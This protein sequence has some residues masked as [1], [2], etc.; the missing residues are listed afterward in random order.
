M[1]RIV[2]VILFCTACGGKLSEDQRKRLH[3]GMATQDIRRVT[4]ADLQ[5]SAL[6][7]GKLVISDIERVD[8]SLRKKSKIDSLAQFYHV[9]IY[10]LV[11]S[12]ELLREVEKQLVDAYVAGSG[13]GQVDDNL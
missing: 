6:A 1:K 9:R 3:E 13:S 12:D 8:I 2:I 11:P 7:Y 4:D 5:E 10:S